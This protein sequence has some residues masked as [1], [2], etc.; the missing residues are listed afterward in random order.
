MLN[1][2]RHGALSYIPLT[3]EDQFL[4]DPTGRGRAHLSS[5][6]EGS[7]TP[8]P[9]PFRGKSR[10]QWFDWYVQMFKKVRLHPAYAAYDQAHFSK[11]GPEGD[12]FPL[13]EVEAQLLESYTLAARTV[14]ITQAAL[15][16]R[17]V[18]IRII[19]QRIEK[20]GYP[21]PVPSRFYPTSG[22]LPTMDKKGTFLAETVGMEPWRHVFVDLP[23]QRSQRL[24]HR[25]IHMTANQDVRYIEDILSSVRRWLIEYVP[26]Y[27]GTWRDP[28]LWEYPQITSSLRTGCISVETDFKSCDHHTGWGLV[29]ALVLPIYEVLIPSKIEFIRFAQFVEELFMQPIYLGDYCMTGDHNL[30]SGQGITNDFETIYDAI[31]DLVGL[32][33][34]RWPLDSAR[35]LNMG[36]DI[37][38]LLLRAKIEDGQRV[39][40]AMIEEGSLNG[41]EFSL[42]KCNLHDDRVHFCRRVHARDLGRLYYNRDGV[43]FKYGAYPGILTLNSIINPER[44]ETDPLN[45]ISS[46]LQ[47]LDNTQGNPL[48]SELIAGLVKGCNFTE[49]L[50]EWTDLSAATYYDWWERVYGTPWDYRQSYSV[51]L[52]KQLHLEKK[53]CI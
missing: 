19:K 3:R 13:A 10:A 8:V 36:D 29:N 49:K 28:K 35:C 16:A 4:I 24:K 17:D 14:T 39:M 25:V 45:L 33:A 53:F 46:F 52:I 21:Q 34:A 23:G 1:L 5:M 31:L 42:E 18:L 11:Y 20:F 15:H 40:D 38:V 37:A 9:Q 32:I 44:H 12:S 2:I 26:E 30:L 41:H 6:K 51:T 47:R 7:P 48:S 27:F 43:P 22:G 50:Q